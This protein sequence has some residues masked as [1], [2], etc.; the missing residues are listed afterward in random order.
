M[1]DLHRYVDY[2]PATN[3]KHLEP[4]LF[5]AR[6]RSAVAVPLSM[7][8]EFTED[9]AAIDKAMMYASILYGAGGFTKFDV[10]RIVDAISWGLVDLVSAPPAPLPGQQQVERAMERHGLVIRSEG[11]TLVD[12]R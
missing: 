1:S 8:H 7:A 12:A 5:I 6:G 2:V 3:G 11:K 4:A 10:Y 9:A